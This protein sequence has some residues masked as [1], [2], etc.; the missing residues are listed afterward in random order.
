[1]TKKRGK[2]P[3]DFTK[4]LGAG[5]ALIAGAFI[6][7]ATDRM[8]DAES[9]RQTA[10]KSKQYQRPKGKPKQ[11]ATRTSGEPSSGKKHPFPDTS[12]PVPARAQHLR[13][14]RDRIS[15]MRR[16]RDQLEDKA[17]S[18]HDLRWVRPAEPS[19]SLPN[20]T[21]NDRIYHSPP[22]E[23]DL[24]IEKKGGSMGSSSTLLRDRISGA[25]L[26]LESDPYSAAY[27]YGFR[28]EQVGVRGE[29]YDAAIEFAGR[30]RILKLAAGRSSIG[31]AGLPLRQSDIAASMLFAWAAT[32][33]SDTDPP[34]L[35]AFA[36]ARN[37]DNSFESS[38]VGMSTL[39]PFA[40]AHEALRAS[41]PSL[42]SL[43]DRARAR[44]R[45]DKR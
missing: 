2:E 11:D 26:V 33:A 31:F 7:R 21:V 14:V 34:R 3:D 32:K 35:V 44:E 37:A 15:R 24:S 12:F 23:V 25:T 18:L 22:C 4:L 40:I 42:D 28:H 8:F 36:G 45:K 43:Y 41:D 10:K 27:T 6:K 9:L 29:W 17:L 1:M 13:G 39:R 38:F 19:T 30:W 5:V 16:Q 20:Q